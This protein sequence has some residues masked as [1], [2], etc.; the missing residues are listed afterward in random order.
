MV[1]IDPSSYVVYDPGFE[2][3][4]ELIDLKKINSALSIL[5]L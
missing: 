5:L 4:F 2:L 3:E 1:R